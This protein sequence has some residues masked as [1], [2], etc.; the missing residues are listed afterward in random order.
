MTKKELYGETVQD[1]EAAVP[2]DEAARDDD[3]QSGS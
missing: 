2:D 1:D 3:A